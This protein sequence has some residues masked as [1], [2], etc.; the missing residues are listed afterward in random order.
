VAEI[1][2]AA[3][4]EGSRGTAGQHADGIPT[5]I[6]EVSHRVISVPYRRP[7]AI[8]SGEASPQLTTIVVTLRTDGGVTGHGEAAPM[9]AY[10]GELLAGVQAALDVLGDAVTGLE[11]TDLGRA[12]QV[13][14][15]TLR[16]NRLAKAAIDVAMHDA[17]ARSLGAPVCSLLG[18][19]VRDRIPLAWVIG[20]EEIHAVVREAVTQAEAGF[21]HIK[22]KGGEAPDRDVQL[23][24]ELRAALPEHVE[25]SLDANEAYD[26]PS[27]G[28]AL[29]H[30]DDLGLDLIEQPLPRWDIAGMARL[31]EGLQMA[32]MA[33]ESVLSPPDALR[34]AEAGA[35]DVINLKLL[36]LGGLRT[37]LDVAAIAGAA[38]LKVKVGSMPELSVA[39]MAA[40]HLAA[41]VPHA[42]VPADLVGPLM[43]DTD[44]L[45]AGD[46]PPGSDGQLPV[47]TGPGLGPLLD[48][49]VLPDAR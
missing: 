47:P 26:L 27:A 23:V 43:V 11:V 35:A 45:L 15:A 2:V 20:L 32:V 13:M 10:T 30:M 18:G 40:A 33:D 36:K 5:T 42:T 37:A 16:G 46:Q 17:A 14:D 31:T 6:V 7:F 39:T 9:T 19:A 41:V 4:P 21:E 49:P 34:V 38:G 48:E 44:P 29:R 28:R 12:H 22:V 3:D 8:S 24:K 25:L 1:S